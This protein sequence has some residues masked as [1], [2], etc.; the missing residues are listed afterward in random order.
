[1]NLLHLLVGRR[2]AN[3]EHGDKK[4]GWVEGVPAMGLDGLGSSSYGPEAA[5]TVLVPLGAA[6][7]VYLGPVIGVI[8]ALLVVLYLS[9]RQTVKACPTSGGAYAVAR[10]NLGE[11]ASLLAAAALMLDY[12]LNVVVGVSAGV[13]ALVSAFP[14]LHPFIVPLCL[15]VVLVV[16]VAVLIPETVKSAW[17]Q[18]LLHM[19]RA[20]A[21]RRALL[22]DGGP[23][24]TVVT[25]P[26]RLAREPPPDPPRP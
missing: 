4:I 22:R 3:R 5:L 25:V 21:L 16:T 20:G 12:I 17:W 15:F 7:I 26:W 14:A 1:M 8:V 24:L 18:N 11:N 13:G 19:H 2:L 23:N 6:G 10:A 9:Y